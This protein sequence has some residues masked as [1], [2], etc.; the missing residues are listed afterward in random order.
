M[1][2]EAIE[3]ATSR[4]APAG[5]EAICLYSNGT[6][7]GLSLGQL[8]I[9]VCTRTAM[10]YEAQSVVK[11]NAITSSAELLRKGADWVDRI[12]AGTASWIRAKA[13]LVDQLGVDEAELPE[14]LKTY[15]NRLK[16]CTVANARMN[17]M[18]QLQQ[19][20]LVALRSYVGRRDVA[21]S[22]ST[23]MVRALGRSQGNV[24]KAI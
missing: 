6:A 11:M 23:N 15:D 10:S 24:A 2:I 7:T 9:A 19:Q 8:I 12:S 20:D 17:S 21:F 16:A 13:F 4:Y 1:A 18:M 14:N 3:I 22:S 5:S